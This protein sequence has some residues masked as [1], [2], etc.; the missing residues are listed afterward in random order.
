M[1]KTAIITGAGKGIGLAITKQLLDDGYNAII[2]DVH[3]VED[4]WKN[5]E[6]LDQ[7]KTEY[8]YI[9]GDI[10]NPDDRQRCLN[11]T[12][13]K[14]GRV[15]ALVNN[16]GVA[17]KVRMDILEM[18]EESFDRVIGI[19]LKATMF[20]TQLVANQMIRQNKKDAKKG[21]IVNIASMSSYVSSI[22]RGEYCVSK[23]GISM[24]TKLF[25]DRLAAEEIYVYEVR[26]G[27]IQ[28]D[29]TAGVKDKY[30][31]L[32]EQGIC[33]IRRWGQP[34]DVANAVSVFCSDK[35][36]YSTGEIINVDGG[37]HIQRL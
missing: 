35:F 13:E 18:Q 21:T 15:D 24:L 3:P 6:I 2:L 32:F 31:A 28:T 23:A 22:S 19:N 27:I 37:F 10:T 9:Q 33:P 20:L 25:A 17:P 12:I 36:L 7:Y 16:A 1:K 29:L 4:V 14:F 11:E 34:E 5:L 30:D 8:H 26:P